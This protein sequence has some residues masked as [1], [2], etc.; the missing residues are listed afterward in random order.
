MAPLLKSLGEKDLE[1]SLEI[2]HWMGFDPDQSGQG[3]AS[4]FSG[5]LAPARRYFLYRLNQCPCRKRLA[6]IGD[7][8][9]SHGSHPRC[10]IVFARNENH[11]QGNAGRSKL[12]SHFDPRLIVQIDI[13]NDAAGLLEILVRLKGFRGFE[14]HGIE[15]VRPQQPLQALQ[16]TRIIIHDENDVG[17]RHRGPPYV[18]PYI[19][20]SK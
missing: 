19:S 6:E 1:R 13:E 14:E 17:A 8:A 11:W 3:R 4:A 9:R 18:R 15:T 5:K 16:L 10:V 20:Q 2:S 7:A 12:M